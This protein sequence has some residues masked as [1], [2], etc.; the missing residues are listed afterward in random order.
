MSLQRLAGSLPSTQ[1]A[2][3]AKQRVEQWIEQQAAQRQT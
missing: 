3:T 1:R 2:A